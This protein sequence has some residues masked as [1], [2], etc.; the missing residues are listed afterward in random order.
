MKKIY[1]IIPFSIFMIN[2][3]DGVKSQAPESQSIITKST[4][5][6]KGSDTELPMVK[7][8]C[9]A[10]QNEHTEMSFDLS[11]GGSGYGIEALI[12]KETDVANSSRA[13]YD[14]ELLRAKRN[15]VNPIQI[16]FS[17]DS[18]AI[19]TNSKLGIDSLSTEEVT[20]IFSGIITNW[21][22]LGGPNLPII[23]YGRDST[24][25]THNY[26]RDK[27]IRAPYSATMKHMR[28]NAEIVNEVQN[29]ISGIGYCGVGFLTN[30]DGKPNGNIW[31]MP[32]YIKVSKVYSPFEREAVKNGN[33]VLARPLYQYID[34]KPNSKLYD[35]IYS[36]L[37]LRGQETIISYGYF[38]ISDYQ[39][40][41]NRL[42]GL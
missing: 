15:G 11:G 39:S 34:G 9:K 36:E 33:Y 27:F 18:S 16:M 7:A 12:K 41:I 14:Y 23:I 8:F 38:P 28:G 1:L 3:K 35:F 20:Q 42:N 37:T 32:I 30:V 29:N 26:L 21:K 25:G 22:S 17:V 4:I 24:S 40:E 5:I 19:I 13:M 10:F 6:I 2:C 31:A